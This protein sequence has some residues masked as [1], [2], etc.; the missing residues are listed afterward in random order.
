M[1]PQSWSLGGSRGGTGSL[2]GMLVTGTD[3]RPLPLE[4]LT[5]LSLGG[6]KEE[7]LQ[8]WIRLIVLL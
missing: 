7:R 5:E 3:A 4:N 8:D 1:I 2:P 6:I